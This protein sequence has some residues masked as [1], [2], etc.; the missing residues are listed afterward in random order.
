MMTF[1]ESDR[2][3]K[4]SK[5]VQRIFTLAVVVIL[6]IQLLDIGY[7][8]LIRNIPLDPLFHIL[9]VIVAIQLPF[10]EVWIYH[11]IWGIKGIKT[12]PVFLLKNT[13][14]RDVM[15]YS[16]EVYLFLWAKKYVERSDKQLLKDLKDTNI[17]SSVASTFF[18]V[19]LLS[20]FFFTGQLTIGKIFQ[21]TNI[22]YL[23]GIGLLVI[24]LFTLAYYYRRYII[25]VSFKIAAGVF[26]IHVFRLLFSQILN[27]LMFFIV[28][29]DIPLDLCFTLIAGEI[30]IM[31]VPFIPN[32]DLVYTSLSLEYVLQTDQA[33]SSEISG[34]LIVRNILNKLLNFL[35]FNSAHILSRVYPMPELSSG[36]ISTLP[37]VE[38]EQS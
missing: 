13:Y 37:A 6:G 4:V 36:E 26:G 34:L 29:P 9:F 17:I 2:G 21:D 1:L 35:M 12:L 38:N 27:V 33:L 16:G 11:L 23:L 19:A 5:W 10:F 3:K 14:N 28:I 25:S 30:V 24:I 18:A 15:G 31:R 32:R 7:D 8:T 22:W 20:V